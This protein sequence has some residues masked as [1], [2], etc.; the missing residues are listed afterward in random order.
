MIHL[1]ST[2]LD[3]LLGAN[4]NP[5]C[6]PTAEWAF[7]REDWPF[8]GRPGMWRQAESLSKSSN[9]VGR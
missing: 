5:F 7:S 9:G 6:G 8:A 2:Q 3:Q 4:A 1:T